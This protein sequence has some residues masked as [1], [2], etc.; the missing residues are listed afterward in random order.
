MKFLVQEKILQELETVRITGLVNMADKQGVQTIAYELGLDTLE[1]FLEK[2]D[3][4]EYAV[5][6][7]TFGELKNSKNRN[8]NLENK[9]VN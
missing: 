1:V 3:V 2:I 5:L 6:L 7:Q 4:K 9:K 8:F